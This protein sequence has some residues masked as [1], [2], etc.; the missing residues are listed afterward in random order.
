MVDPVDGKKTKRFS[1][2][3]LIAL[4]AV[5]AILGF[6]LCATNINKSDHLTILGLMCFFASLLG[7][8]VGVIWAIAAAILRRKDG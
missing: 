1:P 2:A 8:V 6:G 3:K 4:S 5:G 7:I